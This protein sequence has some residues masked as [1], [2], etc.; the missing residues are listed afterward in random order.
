MSQD[1]I[2]LFDNNLRRFKKGQW[3]DVKD[4]I[5]HWLEAQI[6]DIRDNNSVLIH[7]NGWGTRWDEYIDIASDRIRPFRFYT[8][9]TRFT[10]YLSPYPDHK[11]DADISMQSTDNSDVF[12]LNSIQNSLQLRINDLI[13]E[14]NNNR[15]KINSH[16]YNQNKYLLQR[17]NF[18]LTRQLSAI[19]DRF[20]RLTVDISAL[21]D[22][23]LK[24][25]KFEK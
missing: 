7:Y 22:F 25:N 8:K 9:Q 1:S 13:N 14:I 10:N 5:N 16:L 3:V 11:P 18:V 23:C 24:T 17:K 4:T 2:K 15:I 6:I 21:M 20:G 19:M 12:M